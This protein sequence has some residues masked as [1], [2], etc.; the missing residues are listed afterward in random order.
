MKKTIKQQVLEATE[1][2]RAMTT[3][4]QLREWAISNGMDNGSAFSKFKLALR[5]I[6]LDYDLVKSA[7]IDA[8]IS[9]LPEKDQQV[10][11]RLKAIAE[12]LG[13]NLWQKN[14]TRRIYITG[15]NNYHYDGK[16]WVEFDDD[17]EFEVKCWLDS[18]YGNKNSK[19]YMI[20][21]TRMIKDDVNNAMAELNITSNDIAII[22]KEVSETEEVELPISE[23]IEMTLKCEPVAIVRNE[24]YN[25]RL[26]PIK[27]VANLADTPMI[28]HYHGCGEGF[29]YVKDNRVIAFRY[30][31]RPVANEPKDAKRIP[32]EMSCTQLCFRQA[33]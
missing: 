2:L 29:A 17:G 22:P 4:T 25:P 8:D 9:A 12:H 7:Q 19:E 27:S 28:E 3:H 14:G 13:G 16:W 21:H 6:G 10:E 11:K 20:K 1:L 18:G 15:G 31:K 23:E 26:T 24:Y 30:D 33:L 32:V 5:E